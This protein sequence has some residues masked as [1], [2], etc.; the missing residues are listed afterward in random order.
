MDFEPESGFYA[1]SIYPMYAAT[2][3]V[4][5]F[6]VLCASL[7]GFSSAIC[8]GV[9]AAALAVTFPWIFWYSRLA[10]LHSSHRFF[11]DET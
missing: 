9:G 3:L 6:S 8:L 1:G 7:A 10:F 4:G 11:G 2:G 5:G